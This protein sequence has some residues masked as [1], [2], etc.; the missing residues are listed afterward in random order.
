MTLHQKAAKL[1]C[2]TKSEHRRHTGLDSFVK[3]HSYFLCYYVPV[4]KQ[5]TVVFSVNDGAAKDL[6]QK[7]QNQWYVQVR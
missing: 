7:R 4:M 3:E 2:I 6:Q 1:T 5:G